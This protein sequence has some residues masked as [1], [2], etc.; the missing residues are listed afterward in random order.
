MTKKVKREEAFSGIIRRD[1]PKVI[2]CQCPHC[3]AIFLLHTD[4]L[5]EPYRY[6]PC[7]NCGSEYSWNFHMI[8]PI[9]YK[10]KR[11]WRMRD[12]EA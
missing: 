4:A 11:Y 7:P 6:G 1:E 2:P 3:G 10:F 8:S 12:G 5:P 9:E